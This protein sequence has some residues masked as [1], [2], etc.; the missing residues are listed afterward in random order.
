MLSTFSCENFDA[1]LDDRSKYPISPY[2]CKIKKESEGLRKAEL[3]IALKLQRKK[4]VE[5]LTTTHL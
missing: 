5:K 1:V 4:Y 3:D 2:E